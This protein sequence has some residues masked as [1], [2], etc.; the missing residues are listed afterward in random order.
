MGLPT[1]HT[2]LWD[3]SVKST[4]TP[5]A[6]GLGTVVERVHQSTQMDK[7]QQPSGGCTLDFHTQGEGK[8][9]CSPEVTALQVCASRRPWGLCMLSL[10]LRTPHLHFLAT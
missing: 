1:L 7:G 6:A 4:R 5:R 2:H 8:S 9:I 10:L 3:S